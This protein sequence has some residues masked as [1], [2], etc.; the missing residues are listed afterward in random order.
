[1]AVVV[2]EEWLG[3]IRASL[4]AIQTDVSKNAVETARIGTAME[5]IVR[6][7]EIRNGRIEKLEDA[8]ARERTA[9]DSVH[10]GINERLA[11]IE[12]TRAQSAKAP[13]TVRNWLV[14]A[15]GFGTLILTAVALFLR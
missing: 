14:A 4:A 11:V 13:D 6:Q 5:G 15:F 3:E 10:A 9:A 1:M 2:A 8:L 12:A 7:N